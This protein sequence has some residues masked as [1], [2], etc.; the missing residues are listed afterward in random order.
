MSGCKCTDDKV[1][2]DAVNQHTFQ[3]HMSP[4]TPVLQNV[5]CNDPMT[6]YSNMASFPQ[7]SDVLFQERAMQMGSNIPQSKTTAAPEVIGICRK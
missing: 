4:P 1:E 7:G 6:L 3:Y 2:L 5:R